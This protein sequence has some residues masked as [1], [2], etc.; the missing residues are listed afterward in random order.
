MLS[1]PWDKFEFNWSFVQDVMLNVLGFVP[2][3]FL[4]MATLLKAKHR[5]HRYDV[6]IAA[7]LCFLVSMSIEAGQAWMPSRSS[8][9][10]DL[11]LNTLGGV[12]GIRILQYTA[13]RL[14]EN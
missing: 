9:M 6:L 3:G 2:F 12:I 11:M 4:I 14:E 5:Y 10:L 7:M 8:H 13:V 1:P